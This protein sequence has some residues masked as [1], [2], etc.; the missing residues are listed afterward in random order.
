MGNFSVSHYTQLRPTAKSVEIHYVLDLAEIPTFE[1]LRTWE[2]DRNASQS[3]LD[4]RALAQARQWG[5]QL[6]IRSAGRELHPRLLRATAT[7]ADGAGN[8]PIVRVD[9]YWTVSAAGGQLEFEDLNFPDR[10]GWKEIV[11]S[12]APGAVVERASQDNVERSAALRSYPPDPT[13]A[14]PQ[15]LRAVLDWK[16]E[17]VTPR[18]A[19]KPVL[20]RIPQ[21]AS[22]APPPTPAALKKAPPAGAVVRGDTISRLLRGPLS[23]AVILIALAIAFALGAAHALTPGHGKTLVAAYLVGSRG[24]M[25]HAVVLG[26]MVTFTHTIS[27]FLLGLATLFFF[28]FVAPERLTETLGVISGLAIVA[29]GGWMLWKRAKQPRAH[30]YHHHDHGHP[31]HEHHHYV[32]GDITMGSLIALGAS[33]G[34]VPCESALVL[35]LSAIALGRVGLGLML[36]TAFSLGLAI[37]LVAIGMLVLYARHLLPERARNSRPGLLRWAP[38]ASAAAIVAVGVLMTGVSLGLLKPAWL[39][40]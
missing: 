33:G 19:P 25:K 26:A 32:E 11:I 16:A 10:A 5:E 38:V 1:L 3:V 27:V 24:A 35:L 13:V 29:T 30:A 22:P 12:P 28:R 18:A 15:D 2:V 6:T 31:H 4:E 37:V 8:L 39:I 9:S 23:P 14:P 7:V 40:G 17:P 20:A 34:L 21:P 36:L